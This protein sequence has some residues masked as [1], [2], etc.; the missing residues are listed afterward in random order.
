MV[1]KEGQERSILVY[2][3][4]IELNGPEKLKEEVID[5]VQLHAMLFFIS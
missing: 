1:V 5:M 3:E 2:T 4:E